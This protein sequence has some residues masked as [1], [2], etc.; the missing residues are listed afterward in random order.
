MGMMDVPEMRRLYR[1]KRF[2]FWVA[3]AAMVGVLSSAC[4]PA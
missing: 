4:S 1:V 2:D 3:I